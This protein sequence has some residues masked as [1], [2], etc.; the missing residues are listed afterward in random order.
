MR[1]DVSSAL[2]LFYLA[3]SRSLFTKEQDDKSQKAALPLD[4]SSILFKR[5]KK[6]SKDQIVSHKHNQ[7]H[8]LV[9]PTHKGTGTGKKIWAP[10][11]KMGSFTVSVKFKRCS[12][13]SPALCGQRALARDQTEVVRHN[14]AAPDSSQDALLDNLGQWPAASS[15]S[16]CYLKKAEIF[17]KPDN[18]PWFFCCSSFYTDLSNQVFRTRWGVNPLFP[19]VLVTLRSKP[20]LCEDPTEC[21]SRATHHSTL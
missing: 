17:K 1:T 11:V 19:G 7:N 3:L 13:S 21:P 4:Q 20:D 9:L 10:E 15:A 8:P 12:L 14:S 18:N 6:S 2:I 16:A 5:Y